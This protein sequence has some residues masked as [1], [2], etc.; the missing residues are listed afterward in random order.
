MKVLTVIGVIL[1][2]LIGLGLLRL[3]IR[4]CFVQEGTGFSGEV[5]L[6]IL[7]FLGYTFKLDGGDLPARKIDAPGIHGRESN[8]RSG[9]PPQRLPPLGRLLD[10]ARSFLQINFW[11]IEHIK[12]TRFIWKTKL[13][14]GDAA[15]TGIGGGVLWGIKGLLLSILKKSVDWKKCKTEIDVT[16]VF[17]REALA[18]QF[19][20]IF[21]LRTGY[22]IIACCRLL[23]LA[24]MFKLVLKG[25]NS[26]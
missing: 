10:F 9:K 2:L 22:I 6:R 18:T 26:E 23:I 17:D 14:L 8:R 20:C 4:I 16:P 25:A 21:S 1:A 5:I 19:D 12:C 15:A 13:G 7:G 3:K 11:L 24:I